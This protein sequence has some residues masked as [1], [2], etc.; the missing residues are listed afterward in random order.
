[1]ILFRALQDT[2]RNLK[3]FTEK[4]KQLL[5]EATSEQRGPR[6]GSGA[7]VAAP[8]LQAGPRCS[9]DRPPG[10]GPS[11]R[12][13]DPPAPGAR[14]RGAAPKFCQGKSP[15]PFRFWPIY[16]AVSRSGLFLFSAWNYLRL[17]NRYICVLKQVLHAGPSSRQTLPLPPPPRGPPPNSGRHPSS[18]PSIFRRPAPAPAL[19]RSG[20]HAGHRCGRSSIPRVPSAAPGAARPGCELVSSPLRR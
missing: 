1:M 16:S 17:F 12:P 5:P 4:R 10:T 20:P 11:Q 6:W 9:R 14:T 3:S 7:A 13:S 15:L 2:V 8:H 18:L 19:R